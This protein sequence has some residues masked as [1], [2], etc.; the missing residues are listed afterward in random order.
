MTGSSAEVAGTGGTTM[1]FRRL[2]RYPFINGSFQETAILDRINSATCTAKTTVTNRVMPWCGSTIRSRPCNARPCRHSSEDNKARHRTE[3]KEE[4]KTFSGQH[5]AK[6]HLNSEARPCRSNTSRHC[7]RA[8]KM[9]RKA[10]ERLRKKSVGEDRTKT[11]IGAKN[12]VRIAIAIDNAS[13][14]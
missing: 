8:G 5:P 12:R 14:Q 13:R 3:G 1:L 7:H 6:R 4:A 11:A 10:R 2:R 9:L